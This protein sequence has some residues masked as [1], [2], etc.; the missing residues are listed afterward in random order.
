[1]KSTIVKTLN[2]PFSEQRSQSRNPQQ[3]FV[4]IQIPDN[5]EPET[6]LALTKDISDQGV[7]VLTY[8]PLP[9]GTRVLIERDNF[10]IASAEVAD[11]EWDYDCDM[12]RIGLKLIEKTENW[13]ITC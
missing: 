6:M 10:C 4:R 13:P 9:I 3:Y 11:W 1:M 5:E 12:A 8:V 2:N 7:A